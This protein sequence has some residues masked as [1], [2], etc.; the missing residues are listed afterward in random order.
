MSSFRSI[1]D[2]GDFEAKG[3]WYPSESQKLKQLAA[4]G[5]EPGRGDD[6]LWCVT[7]RK[8]FKSRGVFNGHLTGKKHIAGLRAAGRSA[9]A[10]LIKRKAAELRQSQ[11]L[12]KA[13]QVAAVKRIRP[14][15]PGGADFA[16]AAERDRKVPKTCFQP[17]G[18]ELQNEQ[19]REI[20]EGKA[21][22]S[23]VVANQ[24]PNGIEWWRGLPTDDGTKEDDLEHL[25]AAQRLKMKTRGL[26][27]GTG[28]WQCPGNWARKKEC[29]VWNYR[30]HDT[31][32]GCGARKR[33][34]T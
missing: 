8:R 24:A 3:K 31:C 26:S 2:A 33:M 11:K 13:Q 23:K 15:V 1:G 18:E 14:A 30:S 29:G 6:P 9:E 25:T 4:M 21:V 7:C 16:A 34:G 22:V 17:G 32:R 12:Q 19:A 20:V 28:D 27:R 5:P 10:D